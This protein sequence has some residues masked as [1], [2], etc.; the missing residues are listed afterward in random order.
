MKKSFLKIPPL[1][2]VGGVFFDA[3]NSPT[4]PPCPPQGGN[5]T[6]DEIKF[7]TL[8]LLVLFNTITHAQS[9]WPIFRGN[10]QLTG[11]GASA[12]PEQPELL[13]TFEAKGDIE[14]SPVIHAG[15]VYATGLDSQ[16]Y[17][18]DLHSGKLKWQYAALAETKASPAVSNGVVYF[19]DESGAFHAVEVATG[20]RKWL[21]QTDAGVISSA[22]FY[23]DR[24]L[25]GSYD[26]HLYC[27]D[28]H[29]K[30]QWKLE[31]DGYIH[32]TPTIFGE[33]AVVAGCDGVFRMIRIRDGV[34][35]KEA[36][37][38]AYVAAS[39]AVLGERAYVGTFA[40]RVLCF[41]LNS[42]K[43]LW[44]YDHPQ[45]DFP[46]F[47]S[48]AVTNEI[49]IACGRDK[50]VHALNPQDGKVLWTHSAK[51]KIEASPVIVGP[52]VIVAVANGDVL[53]LDLKT[54]KVVWQFE[55][56]S[57]FIASPAIAHGKLVVGST[58]GI[59]YC[60]GRKE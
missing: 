1:R 5:S 43:M 30:L 37:A 27:L 3:C 21:F 14:G 39:T 51:T 53:A 57:S 20:K 10:A 47:A 22:N 40:N 41:D 60:F 23:Q 52:R 32:A 48:A 7:F 2:G 58:E 18:L 38:G 50:L 44:E 28:V 12:L 36:Q 59:I 55:S 26:N 33:L 6:R 25:F 4:T 56:G 13:W 54:G 31:T 34:A 29:G 19:G 15:T 17:A 8:A 9:E 24:V 42:A 49:V 11:V 35:V 45:R 46:F 16:L